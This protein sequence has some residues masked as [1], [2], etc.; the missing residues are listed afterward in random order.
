MNSV[1]G[2]E[3]RGEGSI[4]TFFEV[5]PMYSGST[6]PKEREVEGQFTEL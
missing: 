3:G 5:R 6:V 2:K 4:R 1:L